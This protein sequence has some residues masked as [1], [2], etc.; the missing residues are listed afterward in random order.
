M[1]GQQTSKAQQRL[2]HVKH[3]D[4]PIA[5]QTSAKIFSRLFHVER[6]TAG[7]QVPKVQQ[8]DFVSRETHGRP[9]SPPNQ[10]K[11]LPSA[12]PRGTTD[13]WTTSRKRSNSTLFHVKR[14][15]GRQ[16]INAKNNCSP[17]FHVERP[18]GTHRC[19]TE[20]ACEKLR[21]QFVPSAYHSRSRSR[22]TLEADGGFSWV[23]RALNR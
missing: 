1:G 17:L 20:G 10:R 4:G 7:Q 9:D 15:D 5:Y 11:N 14:M 16:P 13:G 8:R 19:F 3:M 6:Q 12:V 22:S 21:H 18:R 23:A 2:F